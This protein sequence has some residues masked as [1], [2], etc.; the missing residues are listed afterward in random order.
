[1]E[2]KEK[3]ADLFSKSKAQ[4]YKKGEVII[5]PDT[6]PSGVYLILE[7]YVK[8]YSLTEDGEEK[9]HIIYKPDELFPLIW[10]L[11]EIQKDVFYEA[12]T[13]VLAKKVSKGRFLNF[14]KTRPEALFELTRKLSA[15][16]EVFVDRVEN[17][18]IGKS[19]P[20]LI[21]RLLFLAKRFGEKEG[22]S[23]VIKVP[24]THKDIADSIAMSRETAS[25]DISQLEKKG[26]ISYKNHL[27][28]IKDIKELEKELHRTYKRELL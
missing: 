24:L 3:L 26:I 28:E 21:D 17:L 9:L 6:P 4:R 7:G 25:R 13:E 8:I 23:I 16:F 27:I 19:Y 12:L 5:R 20:R 22:G 1:M 14:V 18:E 15:A 10:A 2:T 11:D